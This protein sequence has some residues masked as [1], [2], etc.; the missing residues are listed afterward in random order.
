MNFTDKCSAKIIMKSFLRL[1]RILRQAGLLR[2]KPAV[3][4]PQFS[5]SEWPDLTILHYDCV[6]RNKNINKMIRALFL[7]LLYINAQKDTRI[8]DVGAGGNQ[9][10]EIFQGNGYVNFRG[11]DVGPAIINSRF[12][13]RMNIRDLPDEEIYGVI[14]CA[15]LLDYFPGG[16]FNK[17]DK[18]SLYLLARKLHY[19]IKQGGH[20]IIL[21]TANNM[22][23][24]VKALEKA[25]FKRIENPMPVYSIWQ[26][27]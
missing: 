22:R 12:G 24:F 16:R 18:P 8:L 25:G 6:A 23:E 3:L 14:H 26:K 19:H 17:S 11:I 21:D 4:P 20:L 10:A 13:R 2:R 7:I 5:K 9:L 27:V 1:P 15:S